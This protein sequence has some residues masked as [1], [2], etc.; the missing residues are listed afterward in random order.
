MLVDFDWR[1]VKLDFPFQI[2]GFTVDNKV[3]MKFPDT[4]YSRSDVIRWAK[5]Q[6]FGIRI[7]NEPFFT[8]TEKPATVMKQIEEQRI[9]VEGETYIDDFGFYVYFTV[10]PE[11]GLKDL[12]Y[13]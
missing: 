12:R 8:G 11:E 4:C 5:E 7:S 13:D 2:D 6:K 1:V 9:R 10:V 3:E